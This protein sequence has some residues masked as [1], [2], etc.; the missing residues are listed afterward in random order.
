MIDFGYYSTKIYEQNK[1]VGWWD[2][3]DRCV[4]ECLQLISTEVAEATEGERK[5]LMDDHLPH[6]RMGEVELADAMIRTLDLG[7]RY[8]WRYDRGRDISSWQMNEWSVGRRHLIINAAIQDL[9]DTFYERDG[10]IRNRVHS[11]IE[12]SDLIATIYWVS[13]SFG[14][15]IEAAMIE[16]LE[17][18]KTRADHKRE[19]RAKSNGKKF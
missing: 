14:Y 1:V 2:N 6:R 9:A 7:G 17:Y 10:K 4:L 13:K 5:N 15:D 8:G 3:P 12:Y 19:A 11:D 16:K 18:N